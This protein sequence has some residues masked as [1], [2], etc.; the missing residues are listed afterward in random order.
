MD[1]KDVLTNHIY[2]FLLKVIPGES[3]NLLMICTEMDTS[4]EEYLKTLYQCV[5]S[6]L[7]AFPDEIANTYQVKIDYKSDCA[8]IKVHRTQSI[9]IESIDKN[10]IPQEL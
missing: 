5:T 1:Q 2:Q 6:A 9:D 4:I 10:D 3:R 8:Y 7:Y